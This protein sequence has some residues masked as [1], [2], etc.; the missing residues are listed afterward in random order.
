MARGGINDII[1]D[2]LGFTKISET[3]ETVYKMPYLQVVVFVPENAANA[4]YTA[5]TAA[6]GGEQ[7]N[8]RGCAFSVSGSGCFEPL[9]GANPAI[10]EVGVNTVVKEVRL[11]MLVKP[12]RLKPV[13]SAMQGAHPYEEIAYHIMENGAL[14]E[15]YGYGKLCQADKLY[16]PA[17][18]AKKVKE[19]FKC[20][21]VRYVDAG[22]PI[23]KVA[24]CSGG[25]GKLVENAIAMGADAYIAGDFKHDQFI[26]AK[27]EGISVYDAGH[28]HTENVVL[29]YIKNVVNKQFPTL[30]VDIAKTNVDPLS[31]E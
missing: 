6:G 12:S 25:A 9:S 15:E 31:Y 14:H 20:D 29:E 30:K 11:E 21:V 7:G 19:V 4:V 13:I 16:T 8:Y 18:L 1:V 5:M 24:I 23:K 17:E 22:K 27:N 10:G 2:L 28:Y 26:T 3:L